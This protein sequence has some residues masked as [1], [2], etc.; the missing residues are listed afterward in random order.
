V[1]PPP[2]PRRPPVRLFCGA[3]SVLAALKGVNS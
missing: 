3:F 1:I 2:G